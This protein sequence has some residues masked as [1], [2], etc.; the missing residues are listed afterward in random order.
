[1]VEFETSNVCPASEW[2]ALRDYLTA[3]ASTPPQSYQSR[4]KFGYSPETALLHGQS[5]TRNIYIG[6]SLKDSG[7]PILQAATTQ[8]AVVADALTAAGSLW[9]LSL[10]NVTA[11][12]G[13]GLPLS[14]QSSAAHRITSNYSQPYSTAACI[15]DRIQNDSDSRLLAFPI[16]PFT[17]PSSSATRNQSHGTHGGSVEVIEHPNH[18]YKQLLDTPGDLQDSRL[19]WIE[20]PGDLFNGSSIGAA[21]LLPP[22]PDNSEYNLLLC[23]LAAGWHFSSLAVKLS[24]AGFGIV[25]SIPEEGKRSTKTSLPI[26]DSR[27]PKAEAYKDGLGGVYQHPSIPERA[28][29][30][31]SSWAQ[32]LDPSIEG[33]N[34]SLFNLLIHERPFYMGV[35]TDLY[36][37]TSILVMLLVNGL[38]RTGWGST[39]Q[40]DAKSVGLNG[41]DG[42]LD[43]NYWLSG[44]GDVFE[45]I[46]PT[47]SRDWVTF[48]VE[49]SLQ[50]YAYNTLT[51]PPRIAIAVLTAYCL[52]VAGHVLYT[53]YTGEISFSFMFGL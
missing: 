17:N 45:N 7:G 53:G 49:S 36:M 22:R 39:I 50:G 40:G 13:H 8:H 5:S 31:S 46:D 35:G 47:V 52:L 15:A 43:G 33:L 37:S 10:V 12:A 32:Y 28:I 20:L 44:K 4:F 34:T 30:I 14:D 42:G 3:R 16:L 41:G 29:N 23:N 21:I 11:G 1:M 18:S 48:P 24:S 2:Y 51:T 19:R 26:T 9:Q 6:H 38:A 27:V 25:E